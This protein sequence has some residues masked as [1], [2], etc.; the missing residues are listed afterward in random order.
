MTNYAKPGRVPTTVK[1]KHIP[2]P[3]PSPLGQ[4]RNKPAG[5]A[6]VTTPKLKMAQPLAKPKTYAKAAATPA[7]VSGGFG[8]TGMTG[9]S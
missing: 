3:Y 2:M 1:V 4:H 6:H 7:G 8:D 9:E 5:F